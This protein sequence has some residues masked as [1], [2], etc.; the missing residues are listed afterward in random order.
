[1]SHSSKEATFKDKPVSGLSRVEK[2][3]YRRF[4]QKQLK[5]SVKMRNKGDK[6]N[7]FFRE[8]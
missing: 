4:L 7:E 5:K 8:N 3:Q 1:M 6:P 2:N